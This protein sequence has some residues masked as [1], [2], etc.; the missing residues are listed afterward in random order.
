[1]NPDEIIG[2]TLCISEAVKEILELESDG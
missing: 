2:S 1:M